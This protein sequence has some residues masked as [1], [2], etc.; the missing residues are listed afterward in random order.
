MLMRTSLVASIFL[1]I[2]SYASPAHA[3]FGGPVAAKASIIGYFA[4]IEAADL[5]GVITPAE[6]RACMLIAFD[7]V[8]EGVTSANLSLTFDPNK[9]QVSPIPLFFGDFSESGAFLPLVE[10][11]VGSQLPLEPAPAFDFD[12]SL[13]PRTGSSYSFVVDNTNGT[14]NLSM[15][16]TN[17]PIPVNAAPQNFF[18]IQVLSKVGPV[19]GIQYF[20]T[21]GNY[22]FVQTSF[23]CTLADRVANCGSSTPIEGVNISTVPEPNG[24]LGS[25]ASLG[26]LAFIQKRLNT[27][28]SRP[29]KESSQ[30]SI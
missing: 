30:Q 25:V 7:P 13:S 26:I 28:H 19:S 17:N 2:A 23:S 24:I 3:A 16:F 27:R 21:P 29:S 15:D 5:D 6:R 18:G 11:V 8:V 1:M 4:C 22:D 20:D 14:V 12:L 9:F 10:P